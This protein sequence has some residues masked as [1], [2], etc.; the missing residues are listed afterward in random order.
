MTR[1]YRAYVGTV[2]DDKLSEVALVACTSKCVAIAVWHTLLESAAS[3]NCGGS[4]TTT[5]RR[6]A[7]TLQERCETVENVF[8]AFAELRMV[9]N[10][11]ILAWKKRQFESDS[12]TERARRHRER[13][14]KHDATLHG[15]S[16]TA[17]EAKTETD[18]ELG[19]AN[20]S[21]VDGKPSQRPEPVA[22]LTEARP[23]E[24]IKLDVERDRLAEARAQMREFAE[25]WNGLAAE[26]HLPQI[27]EIKAGSP[28][29]K[30]ALARLRDGTNF[31][32]VFA[33]IRGS[34]FLRGEKGRSPATF[35][36]ITNPTNVIKILEGNYD[37]N[38]QARR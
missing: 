8:A 32:R 27:E 13:R 23:A 19:D 16:A 33:K 11:A 36:W 7:A 2:S 21:L 26:L 5:A 6:V 20:A 1:W 31:E 14:G 30:S 17:P 12:S 4:F 10:G 28:R 38:R 29:E 18:T 34:P 37:E 3:D 24:P 9:E 22:S 25:Q 35:D 15:S